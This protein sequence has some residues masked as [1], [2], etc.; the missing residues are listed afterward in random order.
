MSKK[1]K[2]IV[3]EKL[4]LNTSDKVV[5]IA[6][7]EPIMTEKQ[8]EELSEL[9]RVVTLG[10]SRPHRFTKSHAEKVEDY[11]T[12]LILHEIENADDPWDVHHILKDHIGELES[13]AFH[14]AEYGEKWDELDEEEK[15]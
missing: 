12:L 9:I 10:E 8:R 3:S 7:T 6:R 13:V 5:I 1:L 2:K 15:A 4:K 14:A 11:L